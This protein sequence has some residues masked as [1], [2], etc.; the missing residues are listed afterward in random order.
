MLT[1]SKDPN[2]EKSRDAGRLDAN[3]MMTELLDLQLHT[4]HRLGDLPNRP[5]ALGS[6]GQP[7][8]TVDR[9][10]LS[11]CV[12]NNP[13]THSFIHFMLIHNLNLTGASHNSLHSRI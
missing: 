12:M 5:S 11:N 6:A 2:G 7:T 10:A 9:H 3:G 13:S 4:T 1:T 8:R